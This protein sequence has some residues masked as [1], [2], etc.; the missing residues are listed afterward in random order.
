MLAH[1]P[2]PASGASNADAVRAAFAGLGAGV[3]DCVPVSSASSAALPEAELEPEIDRLVEQAGSIGLL[4]V[5]A[6]GLFDAAVAAGREASKDAAGLAWSALGVCL[7]ASWNVTRLLANRAFLAPTLKDAP[8]AAQQGERAGA[9][10]YIAPA[11]GAGDHADAV[12]AGLENLARTLSVEW[13]RHSVTAVTVAP[14]DSTS[15]GEVAALTAYLASPAGSYFS[16]TL[17][18]LRGA[19]AP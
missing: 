13:A 14:G 18:D 4:V 19:E 15:V 6:A 16:G 9:I 8:S 11:P 7:E 12:R 2:D 3:F 17:L 5:D 10:L 1:A